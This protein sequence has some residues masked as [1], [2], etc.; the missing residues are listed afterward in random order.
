MTCIEMITA[1]ELWAVLPRGHRL[2][3]T[4]AYL[5][6]D[7]PPVYGA[8]MEAISMN[9][10]HHY[11]CCCFL[12]YWFGSIN[13]LLL[14]PQ[15]ISCCAAASLLHSL[16]FGLIIC[17]DDCSF[18]PDL[19]DQ[20]ALRLVRRRPHLSPSL[21]SHAAC[22]ANYFT[23]SQP[24]LCYY[25]AILHYYYTYIPMVSRA[26]DRRCLISNALKEIKQATFIRSKSLWPKMIYLHCSSFWASVCALFTGQIISHMLCCYSI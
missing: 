18:C 16:R 8:A 11:F 24:L 17:V 10:Q 7:V 12:W 1:G 4:G 19:K 22:S 13:A 15:S 14:I 26:Y 25:R 2:T 6:A 20:W 21:G 9:H 3:L 5:W 23:L